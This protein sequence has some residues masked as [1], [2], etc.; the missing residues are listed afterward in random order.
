[1]TRV[2]HAVSDML[3]LAARSLK[4]VRRQPDLLTAYTLQ[5]VMFV[6]LFLFVFGG[7]I[8]TPEGIGYVDFL[9]PGILVQTMAFGGYLTGLS[10]VEDMQRGVIDRFR[11]LPMAP[12]AV[13]GGRTLA[14]V[15]TSILSIAVV[16]L[17]G[18]LLG[19]RFQSNVLE[20]VAG[21]GLLVLFGYAFSWVFAWVGVIATTP[22]SANSFSIMIIFPLTFLSSAFVPPD[23]M[24]TWLQTFADVNPFT[25]MVDA[26]RAL[27]IGSPAGND[28]WA[29][30]AWCLALI[31]TFSTLAVARY[32]A[33]ITR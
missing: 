5:P 28:V 22:E 17:V 11:S 21:F 9:I 1:M 14:D 3:V 6:L 29:A 26:T 27:L 10:L 24:P 33:A 23:T 20:V 4:R 32:R 16:A 7:A 19:F 31:G 2:A 12:S 30:V 13:L 25:T 18:L 15:A 8:G